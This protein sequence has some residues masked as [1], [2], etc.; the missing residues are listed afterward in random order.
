MASHSSIFA[1]KSLNGVKKSEIQ[2]KNDSIRIVKWLVVYQWRKLFNKRMIIQQVTASGSSR[3]GQLWYDILIPSIN[4]SHLMGSTE[5]TH[6]KMINTKSQIRGKTQPP[7]QT[8]ILD[9]ERNLSV[10]VKEI[11]KF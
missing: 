11:N 8:R 6:L 4:L 9:K 7:Q 10:L 2:L 5:I 3:L 1:K